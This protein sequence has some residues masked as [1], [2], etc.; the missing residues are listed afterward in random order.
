MFILEADSKARCLLSPLLSG[1]ALEVL[2]TTVR[3]EEG[4]KGIPMGKG[5]VKSSPFADDKIIYVENPKESKKKNLLEPIN[6]VEQSH[7]IQDTHKNQLH[8]HFHTPTINIWK[9]QLRTHTIYTHS[10]LNEIFNYKFNIYRLC[11]LIITK[12]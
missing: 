4:I 5:K 2:T 9:L 1:T 11:M 6:K 3:K 8:F 7:R 10:K 12:C